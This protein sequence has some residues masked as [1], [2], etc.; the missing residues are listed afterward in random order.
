MRQKCSEGLDP[1][2]NTNIYKENRD[3]LDLLGYWQLGANGLFY[4][5]P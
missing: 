3:S 4:S 1:K 5:I 2:A